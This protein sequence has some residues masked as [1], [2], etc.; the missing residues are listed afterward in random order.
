MIFH[1]KYFAMAI[2]TAAAGFGCSSPEGGP[3]ATES[4][5][6]SQ[7]ALTAN[8]NVFLV[9]HLTGACVDV[10]GAPGTA[11]GSRLQTYPC[12]LSGRDA[13]GGPSDQIWYL[14]SQGFI[15]NQ[16]S[17]DKCIDV[18]GAPGT[19]N[20][21]PLQLYPCESSGYDA[22]GNPTDQRWSYFGLTYGTF[23]N[24]HSGKCI[25]VDGA[26]GWAYHRPVQIWDCEVDVDGGVVGLTDQRWT[27]TPATP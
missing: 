20:G 2:V 6:S 7:Q 11:A 26:P 24:R 12:E 8:T 19:A 25:D 13:W 16:L 15:R 23:R 18:V 14:D 22:W 9:N 3:P 21:T 10:V 1:L 5:K 27:P 17:P 4:I